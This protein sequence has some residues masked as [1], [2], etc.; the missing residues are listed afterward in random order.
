MDGG[1]AGVAA[2]S[3]F[4]SLTAHL[5]IAE[6]EFGC[7]WVLAAIPILSLVQMARPSGNREGS[8]VHTD[9]DKLVIQA[10]TVELQW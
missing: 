2:S 9:T 4:E 7:H 8:L 5:G 6:S 10:I 1:S 3:G